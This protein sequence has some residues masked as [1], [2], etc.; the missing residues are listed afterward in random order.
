[1]LLLS[2]GKAV[3]LKNKFEK[4]EAKQIIQLLKIWISIEEKL[5]RGTQQNVYNMIVYTVHGIN[6][7]LGSGLVTHYKECMLQRGG[8]GF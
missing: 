3:I 6:L 5:A 1:M 8:G 7:F 4:E 2:G